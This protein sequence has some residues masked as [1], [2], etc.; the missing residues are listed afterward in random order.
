[1]YILPQ[2]IRSSLD[3]PVC[4]VC[5]AKSLQLYATLYNPMDCIVRFLCPW[6]SPGKITGVGCLFLLQRIFLTQGLNPCLLCLLW[7]VSSLPLVPAGKPFLYIVDKKDVTG[8]PLS[9]IAKENEFAGPRV[10]QTVMHTRFFPKW[11]PC[12]G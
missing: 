1:M 5:Y 2:L 10:S 4:A 11:C 7:Q 9:W 8:T 12:S 6:D 3:F